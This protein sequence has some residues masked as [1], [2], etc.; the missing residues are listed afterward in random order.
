MTNT[1]IALSSADDEIID[2]EEDVQEMFSY[3]ENHMEPITD[4]ISK[5][6]KTVTARGLIG[7]N[8]PIHT[9]FN[10]FKGVKRPNVYVLVYLIN[11]HLL[12]YRVV[13]TNKRIVNK[14]LCFLFLNSL[15][16]SD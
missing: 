13:I 9:Y 1:Y 15:I 5:W 3:L 10:K 16:F 8:V 7:K 4:L 6:E 2:I 12:H 14:F 11:Y